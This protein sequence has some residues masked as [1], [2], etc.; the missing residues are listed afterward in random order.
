MLR[1][2][3]YFGGKQDSLSDA[4]LKAF[5]SFVNEAVAVDDDLEN[6]VSTCF[7]EDL[8]HRGYK[9]LKPHLSALAKRKTHA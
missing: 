3:P 1:F 8:S 6:A 5:G 7:L 4:Q 9:V 2:R